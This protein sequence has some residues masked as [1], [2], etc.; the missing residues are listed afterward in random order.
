MSTLFDADAVIGGGY[1]ANDPAL[2]WWIGMLRRAS[3]LALS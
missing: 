2:L 1:G 3:V